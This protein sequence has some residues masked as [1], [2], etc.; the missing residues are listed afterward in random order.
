MADVRDISAMREQGDIYDYARMQAGLGGRPDRTL[1]KVPCPQC[2]APPMQ[3][4]TVTSSGK[5]L[6]A[7]IH[8]A[9]ID[10]AE[11]DQGH[12]AEHT[13]GAWPVARR[14]AWPTR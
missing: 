12:P 11:L 1:E 5:R 8:Q 4:C 13:P 2:G 7:K 14:G 3:S 6:S 10:A 9:R